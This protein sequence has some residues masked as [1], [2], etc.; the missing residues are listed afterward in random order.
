M[1]RYRIFGMDFVLHRYRNLTTLL[2]VIATQ[3]VLIAYQV[4]SGQDMRLLRVWSITAVTPLAR[5]VEAIRAGT[6]GFVQ[7]YFILL[8]AREENRNLKQDLDRFKL[9]NQ[10]LKTQLGDSERAKALAV[11]QTRI[12]SK[13]IAARVIA[14]A[15]GANSK[16]VYV[17]L[18]MVAGIQP[19]M[20]VIT[21]DGIV[22]KVIA[23]Y[24]TASQVMLITDPSFAAGVISLKGRARGALKGQGHG[25]LLVDYVPSEFKVE[26][27]EMFYTSGDDRIF[28]K[29]LPVGEVKMARPGR[30]YKEIFVAPTG[31][32]NGLE[33]VLIVVEGVHQIEPGSQ[34]QAPYSVMPAPPSTPGET[35]AQPQAQPSS[36]PA[37]PQVTEADRL[38][39]RYKK[40]GEAQGLRYGEG[41]RIPDFTQNPDSVRASSPSQQPAPAPPPSAPPHQQQ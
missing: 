18:G 38:R 39:D 13:T 34:E 17:D 32:R 35:P 12:P 8:K 25:T 40:I 22:G 7:D 14:N 4:K 16:V 1:V 31:F 15:T 11:F 23:V 27:G 20:A 3:L 5:F 36:T 9:E 19:G 26:L 21:P 33:E 24:P 6:V 2:V 28:P 10:F 37:T 29:G 41:G 30:M